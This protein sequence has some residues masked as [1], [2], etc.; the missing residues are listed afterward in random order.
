M[1]NLRT[2]W[3]AALTLVCVISSAWAQQPKEQ[4]V[5][6]SVLFD[7]TGVKPG[8]SIHAAVSL[9]IQQGWHVNGNKPLEE[10]LIPT[11]FTFEAS[12]G[13]VVGQTIYPEA[14]NVK[15][16]FSDSPVAVYEG[17]VVVGVEFSVAT[18]ASPGLKTV[19]ATLRYQACNDKQC[20]APAK[21][22]VEFAIN[23]VAA[24][25]DV[26]PQNA[27]A[28]K[29]L[30]F[31]AAAPVEVAP[32]PAAEVPGVQTP[33]TQGS[34]NELLKEFEVTAQTG[35]YLNSAE[36]LKFLD[37]AESGTPY[38]Q[39]GMFAG[40][41]V[42]AIVLLTLLGGLALNL[43]PCVLP[44]I[45]I[46]L[47]IIGA[48]VKAGSRAKGFVLGG[49]YG[50]GI[51]LVYGVLGLVAV[52]GAASFGSINSSPWFNFGIAVV[53]VVL[54]LAMFDILLI[55]FT[56]FQSKLGIKK[57]KGSLLFAFVMG[58]VNALLA[59]ACVAPVVIA[60]ILY[61]QDTY[62]SGSP[63]GLVLP[64]LLGLG[65]ALPWPFA[66]AGLSMLP[67]PGMWMVRVKQAFG[68]LILVF[69]AYYGYLG[70]TLFNETYLVDREQVQAS[71]AAKGEA[72]WVSSLEQGLTEAKKQGKPVFIDFWATW[73]KNCL[74]MNET[75]FKDPA[76]LKRLEGYIKVKYQAEA[77]DEPPAKDILSHFEYVGLPHYA[78]LKPAPQK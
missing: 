30:S 22:P 44:L 25:A 14:K 66:G 78:V 45:P 64:F 11:A 34:A 38:S 59:G 69:A 33:D 1:T 41:G 73:C 53:F 67:K 27:E 20:L 23:V 57:E 16:G 72:G 48:G 62:A 40:K 76:V 12:E 28:F 49:F 35:G 70:Y 77:P 58:A 39:T 55:D 19:P 71:A 6:A 4:T 31:T 65:M 2:L 7:A 74:V 46:N 75:T 24:D 56:K 43:T 21:L 9:T 63:V 52:F 8:G 47:A 18:D 13:I 17:T 60:V 15:L 42:L 5:T 36:F 29:A 68:V 37:A 32:K 3:L 50:L 61:A 51:A 26:Q 10:F 54:A